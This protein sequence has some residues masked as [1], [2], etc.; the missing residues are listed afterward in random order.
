MERQIIPQVKPDEE[1]FFLK[2]MDN[3]FGT[4][5]VFDS[6]P[7]ANQLNPNTWGKNGTDIY[8]KFSDGVVLRF[9]GSVV[10]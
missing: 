4:P 2:L 8:V 5:E 7:V 9:S 3:A 1:A 6:A 10:A